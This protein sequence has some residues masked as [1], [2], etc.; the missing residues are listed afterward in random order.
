MNSEHLRKIWQHSPQHPKLERDLVHLWRVNLNLSPTTI[1]ELAGLLSQDEM[2]KAN[3]FRFQKHKR[4]FVVARGV[5]RHL[6]GN[7]L[8]INPKEVKFQY[9]DRGKPYL[10]NT[11]DNNSLQFNI[12]HSQEYALHG[13]VYNH[14]IG[15]DLEYLREMK[16]AAQIAQ[17]FFSAQE[18][19]LLDNLDS[20]QQQRLFFKLWTAKEA[21]LKATGKGLAD[22]LESVKIDFDQTE[23]PCLKAIQGCSEAI[24]WWSM[25]PCIPAQNYVGAIAIKAQITQEQIKYW[26]WD[27]DL[28]GGR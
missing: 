21:C 26:N 28:F 13:F 1:K 17:R 24:K 9:G 5:L 25:Y 11:T 6:L 12:S 4:R 22:S 23:V 20:R 8:Q 7:Y 16:D 2:A 15:V 10:T 18:F 14:P 27:R 19:R 3:R